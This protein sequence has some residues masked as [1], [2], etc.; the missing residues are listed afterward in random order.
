MP[1]IQPLPAKEMRIAGTA[2]IAIRSQG[3]A[4]SAICAPG[5]GPAITDTSGTA[6]SC[7]TTTTARPRPIA[8]QVACTP[9]ATAA[10][11][12]PTPWKRAERAVVAVD[13]NVS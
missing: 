11:R 5:P 6:A 7:T 2:R 13:R 9:S 4:V 3:S 12:L 8:S 1:R 10:A